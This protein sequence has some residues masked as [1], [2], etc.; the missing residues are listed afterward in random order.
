MA[1]EAIRLLAK[2]LTDPDSVPEQ[3]SV[4][5]HLVARESTA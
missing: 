1:R 3:L 5:F 4:P 2:Q